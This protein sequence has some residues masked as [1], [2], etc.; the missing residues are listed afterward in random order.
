MSI[1]KMAVNKLIEDVVLV[2]DKD[3]L[4]QMKDTDTIIREFVRAL[5][6][7]LK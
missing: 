5:I 1:D 2:L 6:K 4:E 7:E 3:P